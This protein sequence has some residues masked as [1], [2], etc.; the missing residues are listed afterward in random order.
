M[1]SLCIGTEKHDCY[2]AESVFFTEILAAKSSGA[3]P[4]GSL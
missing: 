2:T 4:L 1:L 3:W